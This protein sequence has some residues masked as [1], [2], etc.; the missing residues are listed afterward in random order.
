MF[1]VGV[2]NLARPER[3]QSELE[4]LVGAATAGDESAWNALVDRFAPLVYAIIRGFRIEAAEAEDVSQTI[5]LRLV[6]HLGRLRD[7]ER[8][9]AWLAATTRNECLRALRLAARQLPT[10]D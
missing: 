4:R 7:P 1:S 9:G 3:E 6:E 5:W 2:M 10:G 8:V